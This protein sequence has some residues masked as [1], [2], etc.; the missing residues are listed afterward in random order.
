MRQRSVVGL[1]FDIKIDYMDDYIDRILKVEEV[2]VEE[3]CIFFENS[4][5]KIISI[6][7][8]RNVRKLTFE[9]A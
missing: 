4:E 3:G 6:I 8:A 5:G 1:A 2:T 7:P 9:Y